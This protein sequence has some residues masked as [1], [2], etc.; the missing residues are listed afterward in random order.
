MGCG[1]DDVEV[2]T[3][4]PTVLV[5][6]GW[7]RVRVAGRSLNHGQ[8]VGQAMRDMVGGRMA[9]AVIRTVDPEIET[10]QVTLH[11]EDFVDLL[12]QAKVGEIHAAQDDR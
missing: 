2:S 12:R 7:W 1:V 6:N 9:P 10:A 11:L 8:T 3:I 4:G 5:V